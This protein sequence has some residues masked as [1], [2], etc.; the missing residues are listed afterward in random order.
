LGEGS[1]ADVLELMPEDTTYDSVRLTLGVLVDKG[2]LTHRREGRRYVYH[3]AV[4]LKAASRSAVRQLLGTYFRESPSRA[5]LTLLDVSSQ[6]LSDEELD[7]IE[8][9]VREAKEGR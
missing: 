2:H 3:P 1:V 5:I 9:W 8:A 7:R 6:N 4:P